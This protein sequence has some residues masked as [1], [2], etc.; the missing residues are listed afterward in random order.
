MSVKAYLSCFFVLC[1]GLVACEPATKNQATPPAA[2][3]TP[4]ASQ[5][6]APADQ[7]GQGQSKGGHFWVSYT[8]TPNPI[9]FEDSF[10]LELKVFKG[11]DKVTPLT[12]AKLDQ[13]RATMPS[14]HHGMKVEPTIVPGSSP[15]TFL[16]QGMRFHMQ[17]KGEDGRWLLEFVLRDG[18]TIETASFDVQCC[19]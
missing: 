19:R 5:E 8:P 3:P 12:E 18:A 7:S 14:H 4:E 10:D 13:V 11:E 17:G 16:I 15:G 2:S 9:P 1:I 6:L